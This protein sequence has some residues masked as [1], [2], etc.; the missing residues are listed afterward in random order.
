MAVPFRTIVINLYQVLILANRTSLGKF[1]L[2]SLRNS[3]NSFST[4][5]SS[6]HITMITISLKPEMVPVGENMCLPPEL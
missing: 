2:L 3:H 4:Y 6:K 1:L 5:A